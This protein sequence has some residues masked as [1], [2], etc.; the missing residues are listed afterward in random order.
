LRYSMKKLSSYSG[1]AMEQNVYIIAEYQQG[2]ISQETFELVSFARELSLGILPTIML[3]CRDITVPSGELAEKTGCDI[4]AITGESLELYNAHI[5]N[6]AILDYLIPKAPISVC[7]PHTSMGYDLAPVLAV[8]L[9][10]TCITAVEAIHGRSFCRSVYSGKFMMDI[11]PSAASTVLTVQPGAFKPYKSVDVPAGHITTIDFS[12]TSN[13]SRTL[14]IKESIYRD[15]T[16]KDAEVIVSAG[17]GIGKKDNI[18]LVKALAKIFP[19]SAVGAS[20]SVCD[21]GWLEYKHQIGTTGQTISPRLYIACGISG[22]IQHISGMKTS[23]NI[24]AINTD[25]H[26]AIFHIAHYCIVEDL[27][28]FIPLLI[29]EYKGTCV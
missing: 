20:R 21:L 12:F 13:R 4:I 19:K 26:A 28:V 10:A 17:R 29:E 27:T 25:P 9:D 7:L 23:Q 6:K 2:H 22:A 1:S 8:G 3:L 15:S 14:S 18:S 5:Y 24:I 11:T 16:L